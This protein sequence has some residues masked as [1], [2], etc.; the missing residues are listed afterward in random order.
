M[1]IPWAQIL[2]AAV[3]NFAFTSALVGA[4]AFVGRS[5]IGRWLDRDLENYKAKLQATN[6]TELERL[7]A[8]L[9]LIAFEHETRFAK[10]HEKRAEVI[11]ELYKRLVRA[12]NSIRYMAEATQD[13]EKQPFKEQLTKDGAKHGSEFWTYFDEHRIYFNRDLCEKLDKIR[14]EFEMVYIWD[15]TSGGPDDIKTWIKIWDKMHIRI[16]EIRK[17]IENT[18]RKM[19]GVDQTNDSAQ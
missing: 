9:E 18:F 12:M 11:A 2:I 1:E 5:L 6:A 16:P 13:P 10:L 15:L 17:D 4:L 8:D 7:R 19:L 14:V 3:T